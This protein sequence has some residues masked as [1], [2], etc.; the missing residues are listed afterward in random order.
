MISYERRGTR[1][2]K[3]ACKHI[4]RVFPEFSVGTTKLTILRDR[5]LEVAFRL[6]KLFKCSGFSVWRKERIV[7][8]IS[9]LVFAQLANYHIFPHRIWR[10]SGCRG[11]VVRALSIFMMSLTHIRNRIKTR[12]GELWWYT[13]ILFCVQRLGDV[14]NAF[15]GLWLVPKYVSQEEL[16]AVLPLT[17]V[18]SVLGLPLTILLIP[19]TKFLNTYATRGEYGKVKRLLYDMF[20]LSVILFVGTLVYA[21]FF[22]PLVF[23][24]MRVAE[25]SL[26]L[27][28]VATGVISIVSTG[29]G[30]ALQALKHF[31]LIAI[32]SLLA[33]PFRLI[34]MLVF[35]PFRAISGYFLGQ[36]APSALVI[37]IS[38]FGLRQKLGRQVKSEGYWQAD[39]I[40]M[41]RYTIPVALCF[42]AATLQAFAATFVIRH[43]LPEM[44]SAGYYVVSRFAE[45]GAYAGMTLSFVLFPLTAE[46][47][48]RGER[49]NLIVWQSMCGSLCVGLLLAAFF[50]FFGSWLLGLVPIWRDYQA[51][52]PQMVLLTIIQ[53]LR[54]SSGCFVSFEMACGRF[55]FVGYCVGI[56]AVECVLLYG[57]TGYTFFEGWLPQ[58]WVDW[59]ASL[60]AT[61]IDFILLLMLWSSVVSISC[62]GLQLIG[63][64][65][66]GHMNPQFQ[67]ILSLK[68]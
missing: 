65:I 29:F 43:R 16:G 35:M 5:L 67:H 60:N 46:K 4:S 54:A 21:R 53:T 56:A 55:K 49:S 58:I 51:Y 32:T 45:I 30:N 13:L 7:L 39:W 63:R 9:F 25:G 48:E 62:M 15:V 57:L 59:M 24:R 2:F 37:F 42:A 6:N 50:H 3:I 47:H 68:R 61:R 8:G 1:W 52:T 41:V 34:T 17:Q 19:F 18:G 36:S 44:D 26:G 11:K 28:I 66:H 64:K 14:I 20:V 33:A 31:R 23:T 40:R 27:L 12:L 22:M 10:L 38:L